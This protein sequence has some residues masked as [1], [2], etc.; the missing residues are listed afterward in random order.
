[1]KFVESGSLWSAIKKRRRLYEEECR[2]AQAEGREIPV[3]V[4]LARARLPWVLAVIGGVLLLLIA[5]IVF[6]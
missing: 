2:K 4:P 5:D 3:Y 1:M 6:N